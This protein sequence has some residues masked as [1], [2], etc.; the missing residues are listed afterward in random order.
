MW[1]DLPSVPRSAGAKTTGGE[2]WDPQTPAGPGLPQVNVPPA[3]GQA[4][5][6]PRNPQGVTIATAEQD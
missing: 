3:R 6:S 1:G 2:D 4:G 5:E